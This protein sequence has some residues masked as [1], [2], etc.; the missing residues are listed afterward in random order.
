M[1]LFC[2]CFYY[3][4]DCLSLHDRL[5]L[6]RSGVQYKNENHLKIDDTTYW[7]DDFKSAHCT[8]HSLH[9]GCTAQKSV[10]NHMKQDLIF[11]YSSD[12]THPQNHFYIFTN[13]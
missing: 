11:Q 3:S 5:G 6:I 12:Q 1:L 10:V 9:Q 13:N 4:L 8:K 7:V 2:Y